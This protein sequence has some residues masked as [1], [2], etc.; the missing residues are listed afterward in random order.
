MIC[1]SFFL[2]SPLL[3]W[4][5]LSL[6]LTQLM[7]RNHEV[8]PQTA[9]CLGLQQGLWSGRL[10]GG[11]L[12]LLFFSPSSRPRSLGWG[13]ELCSGHRLSICPG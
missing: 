12:F 6:H 7:T 4:I 13:P 5:L 1:S 9:M 3:V 11:F 2:S 8:P 10:L